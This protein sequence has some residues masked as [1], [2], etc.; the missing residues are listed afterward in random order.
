MTPARDQHG[1]FVKQQPLASAILR[2]TPPIRWPLQRHDITALIF[3]VCAMAVFCPY[4]QL[5]LLVIGV[6]YLG[7]HDLGADDADAR[8]VLAHRPVGR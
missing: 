6:Y 2:A 8:V 4:R 5:I 7:P 3:T 1:R